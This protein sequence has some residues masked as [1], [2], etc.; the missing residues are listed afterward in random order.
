MMTPGRSIWEIELPIAL[1]GLSSA[2][3]WSPLSATATRNLPMHAAGAGS[4]VYTV[5]I[6][7]LREGR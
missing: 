2:F 4:G 7:D 5:H 3:M 6:D 1:M